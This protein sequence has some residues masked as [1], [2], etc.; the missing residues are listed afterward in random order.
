MSDSEL[1]KVEEIWVNLTE[2]SEITGYNSGS[3]RKM[4]LTMA[5]EP[6]ETRA[7][8]IRKRSNGWEMWLPDLMVYV[9]RAR[10]GPPV[11]RNK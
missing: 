8:R 1:E 2:A 6:E 3:L 5:Q 7:V 10:R 11:K 9:K 4:A